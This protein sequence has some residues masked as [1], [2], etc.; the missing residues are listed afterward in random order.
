METV[1]ERIG[2]RNKVVV[3]HNHQAFILQ[4]AES[5]VK[6]FK[7]CFDVM[8][9]CFRRECEGKKD[10][11][12][13]SNCNK[14]AVINWVAVEKELPHPYIT[15]LICYEKVSNG[16]KQD[17]MTGRWCGDSWIP[18]GMKPILTSKVIYWAELPKPP[19]L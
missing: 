4:C 1:I 16:M 18:D 10:S 7:H 14:P 15:V 6:Y 8:I 5:E 19:C 11:T 9:D 3:K 13:S 2:G 12:E 17:I